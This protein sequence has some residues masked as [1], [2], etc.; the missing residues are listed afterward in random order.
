MVGGTA[1]QRVSCQAQVQRRKS[2][3]CALKA[4]A[5]AAVVGIERP[6]KQMRCWMVC[7]SYFRAIRR[8]VGALGVGFGAGDVAVTDL[9]LRWCLGGNLL[10]EI[11]SSESVEWWSD[12]C[13]DGSHPPF[14]QLGYF[15]G[16]LRTY[17]Q[18]HPVHGF[19]S[20]M[21]SYKAVHPQNVVQA[22]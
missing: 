19:F 20:I 11:G 17:H 13:Y 1:W 18:V 6:L 3:H 15:R 21:D 7:S 2:C 5:A 12:V 14:P 8:P 4:A 22:R 10:I 9:V 16:A